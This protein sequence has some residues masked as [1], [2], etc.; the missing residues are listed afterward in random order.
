MRWLIVHG[1]WL[2]G[3][4]LVGAFGAGACLA[5]GRS[6]RR[7]QGARSVVL[8]VATVEAG[9]SRR[10][11]LRAVVGGLRAL[12]AVLV[13][14]TAAAALSLE[15]AERRVGAVQPGVPFGYCRAPSVGLYALALAV[16]WLRPK[17]L[18]SLH[19]A[20]RCADPRPVGTAAFADT[21]LRLQG[22]DCRRRMDEAMAF[23]DHRLASAIAGSCGD[24]LLVSD[25]EASCGRFPRAPRRPWRREDGWSLTDAYD[26]ATPLVLAGE[27]RAAAEVLRP[28]VAW[29]RDVRGTRHARAWAD[30]V[31]DTADI[32]LAEG[33]DAEARERLMDGLQLVR[34][35]R[36]VRAEVWAILTQ[37]ERD[38][39]LRGLPLETPSWLLQR[40]PTSDSFRGAP[41]WVQRLV[42]A[43]DLRASPN[44]AID[45]PMDEE[46]YARA[47]ALSDPALLRA[48]RRAEGSAARLLARAGADRRSLRPAIAAWL[49][50]RDH[51]VHPGQPL[52]AGS[53]ALERLAIARALGD[54]ALVAETRTVAEAWRRA[55]LRPGLA[56]V[57]WSR[58]AQPF[59]CGLG[60]DPE[61]VKVPNVP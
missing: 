12:L 27:P 16:P 36:G 58:L 3:A 2:F 46:G 9:A 55:L 54:P 51:W 53:A 28:E 50:D 6:A 31:E 17:A 33:G 43:G 18:G 23:N 7:P 19:L 11:W 8:E 21:L 49:R 37:P 56:L 40:E 13:L 24:A 41:E 35:G 57:W 32:L 1:P 61:P 47:R 10:G 44:T 5:R 30:A 34:K 52:D 4:L 60:D 59:D 15:A 14:L 26:A 42:S 25:V 22:R 39:F 45:H 38:E 48:L 20:L 29:L